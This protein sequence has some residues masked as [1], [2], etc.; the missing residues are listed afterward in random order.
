VKWVG[1][2]FPSYGWN[3]NPGTSH[4]E[5][6]YQDV[7]VVFIDRLIKPLLEPWM[8]RASFLDEI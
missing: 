4:S 5:A 8:K 1:V 6:S 2:G 7:L 3:K